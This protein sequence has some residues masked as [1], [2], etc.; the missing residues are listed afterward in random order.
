MAPAYETKYKKQRK[1]LLIYQVKD[2][3]IHLKKIV[4]L[5]NKAC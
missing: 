2:I 1:T 4:N 5:S 3:L